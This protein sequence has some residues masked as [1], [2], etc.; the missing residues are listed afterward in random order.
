MPFSE[1]QDSL[2]A[3]AEA[4]AH[5][6]PIDEDL[7][8]V[9]AARVS[10]TRLPPPSAYP[11]RVYRQNAATGQFE[12]VRG[13]G[14][15]FGVRDGDDDGA[16]ASGP[17]AAAGLSGGLDGRCLGSGGSGGWEGGNPQAGLRVPLPPELRLASAFFHLI[18][19]PT[20]FTAGLVAGAALLEAIIFS[21]FGNLKDTH[22]TPMMI[23]APAALH[24]YRIM[25]WG[26]FAT[27]VGVTA[28]M[29]V[30]STGSHYFFQPWRQYLDGLLMFVWA[31]IAW[32]TFAGRS[33]PFVIS[34]P[35]QAHLT[36]TFSAIDAQFVS[37]FL[38][39][40]EP[41]SR[42]LVVR[43]VL[44][45]LAALLT[46]LPT[47]DDVFTRMPPRRAT[48]IRA[49]AAVRPLDAPESASYGSARVGEVCP[50]RAPAC[51]HLARAP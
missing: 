22:L 46:I 5:V 8:P 23:Y 50:P 19:A 11:D 15:R 20:R 13:R 42:L 32:L 49:R 33:V 2:R 35:H 21:S 48:A 3:T 6:V 51:A 34:S 12:C 7:A 27:F 40:W 10:A 44:A 45:L 4:L 9:E 37:G 24:F 31:S 16:G 25:L 26:S 38:D 36:P 14:Q 39:E 17:S 41:H 30:R 18:V 43:R 28:A 1:G 47:T 29:L